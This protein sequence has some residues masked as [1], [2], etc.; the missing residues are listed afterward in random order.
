MPC[1]KNY[2]F[3]PNVWNQRFDS[4]F[5]SL[6]GG[7][8][9]LENAIETCLASSILD[10]IVVAC[11]NL[12]A[13]DLMKKYNDPRLVFFERSTQDTIRSRSIVPLLERITTKLDPEKKGISIMC[14]A[15]S[16]FLQTHTIEEAL[17]TLVINEVDSCFGVEELDR[18]VYRKSPY[19]LEQL[20]SPS[21]IS[22]D[23]QKVYI[24]SRT[25][26]A[27]WNKNFTTGSLTGPSVVHFTVSKDETFFIDSEESL[28]I[29]WLLASRRK[30]KR[31]SVKKI[32]AESA[33]LTK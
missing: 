31:H 22:T 28:E 5:T 12:E 24:E 3:V 33:P 19:G 27:A 10:H 29:A 30:S 14:Y 23:S 13:L 2:D 7:K 11:D 9:L 32:E 26:L 4:P 25:V 15:Q 16:P 6:G 20:N 1:R 8:T 21:G 18:S 17:F